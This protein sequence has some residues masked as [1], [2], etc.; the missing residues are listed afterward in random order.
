MSVYCS[1]LDSDTAIGHG[2]IKKYSPKT[3]PSSS[4]MLLVEP[5]RKKFTVKSPAVV[6]PVGSDTPDKPLEHIG[7]ESVYNSVCDTLVSD[8]LTFNQTRSERQ[9]SLPEK[10][11][12]SV[13]DNLTSS[14]GHGRKPVVSDMLTTPRSKR[15]VKTALSSDIYSITSS[16][17]LLF[18]EVTKTKSRLSS[19]LC[20]LSQIHA[21][22][23]STLK[24]E[25]DRHSDTDIIK[26]KV[27]EI[28][29]SISELNWPVTV[30]MLPKFSSG[31]PFPVH[32][33]A[34]KSISPCRIKSSKSY[35][36]Y[37]KCFVT[38]IFSC[39]T[40]WVVTVW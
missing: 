7:A 19:S 29:S 11:K 17:T 37:C 14:Y 20:N 23:N 22:P 25:S 3:M 1:T 12:K 28:D 18:S 5:L 34:R 27:D 33:S 38:G 39:L 31:L 9:A 35:G 15:T 32:S 4:P 10:Y 24:T 30:P 8:K 26:I 16:E 2:R 21:F 40:I 13:D 6:V 36:G